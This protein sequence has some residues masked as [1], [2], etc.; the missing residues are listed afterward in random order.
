MPQE[1]DNSSGG[2]VFV[3]DPRWGPLSGRL[4]HTSFGKGW[5]YYLMTQKVAGTA[6]AAVVKLDLDASTGIH[7]AQVNPADGQ[8]YTTGL[9]GWNGGGRKGL[10]QGG[11]HRFRYTGK[12][13][14]LL[15]DVQ[16]EENGIR[17]SFNF[18]L[19]P[20]F[21]T[22]ADSYQLSQWNYLW[23]ENYGSAQYSVTDAWDEGIDQIE[24]AGVELAA[25]GRSVF[26]MIPEIQPVNQVQIDL[27]I[28]ATDGALFEERAYLTI[29]AVPGGMHPTMKELT[30]E[31][32]A[33]VV[34]NAQRLQDAAELAQK[35]KREA[36]LKAEA[37]GKGEEGG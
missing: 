16:V 3:D 33:F 27:D 22:N 15:T 34:E 19:S 12:P 32:S 17:L 30:V 5:L 29:N 20:E 35:I 18:A 9:N 4:L 28:I 6:Q 23:T 25:D 2:Q 21:A 37:E 24:L 7:R 36:R 11:I 14:K 31:R 26:L 8:V 10:A 13:A 1:F